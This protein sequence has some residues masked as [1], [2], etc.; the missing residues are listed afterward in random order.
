MSRILQNKVATVFGGTGFIGRYIVA[1]LAKE[2]ATV[3]V[4]TRHPSSAYFLRQFGSVGQIVPVLCNYTD[5]EIQDAVKGSDYVVNCLGILFEKKRDQFKQVHVEL[6]GKIAKA[7][8]AYKVERFI[9][10]SAAGIELSKSRYAETKL[11]GEKAVRDSYPAATILRPS[12]VFGPEDQFFNK[13]AKLS[14]FMPALPVIGGSQTR[15]QPVYAGDVADAAVK[16]ITLPGYGSK[17]PL[18]Q[19]YELGGP[20]KLTLRQ[21]YERIFAQ[22]GRKRMIFAMPELLARIQAA[23]LSALPNPIL[24][25]DQITSLKSDNVVSENALALSDLGLQATAIDAHLPLYLAHY[26]AGGRFA[27]K[28]RA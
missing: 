27:E 6:A 25:N 13:F 21:I 3:K 5:Q 10:L 18:G 14:M 9:H 12:V 1:Q 28:K 16:A 15:L 19:T 26:R 8:A 23:F 7:C 2:G 20:E 24:T 17:S 4:M 22:T 11:M